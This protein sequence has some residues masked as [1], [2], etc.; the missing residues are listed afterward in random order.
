MKTTTTNI[1]KIFLFE[2]FIFIFCRSGN[3]VE[4]EIEEVFK[5]PFKL[6]F[7]CSPYN[8]PVKLPGIKFFY[9]TEEIASSTSTEEIFNW[10]QM[11]LKQNIEK[12]NNYQIEGEIVVKTNYRLYIAWEVVKDG[13]K[14]LEEKD[15]YNTTYNIEEEEK[16][17]IEEKKY[18]MLSE[19]I[20]RKFFIYIVPTVYIFREGQP[21]PDKVETIEEYNIKKSWKSTECVICRENCPNV[22]YIKCRHIVAC[23]SCD[24]IGKLLKCPICKNVLKNQRIKI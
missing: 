20:E 16:I 4:M 24:R 19:I 5:S 2:I 17:Q 6:V 22:L 21:D 8:S 14:R 12:Y 1:F 11:Y 3:F 7:S 23:D 10:S 9:R 13:L 18:Y 15:L